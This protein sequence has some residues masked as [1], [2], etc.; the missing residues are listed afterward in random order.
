MS[1][2]RG[3]VFADNFSAFIDQCVIKFYGRY[4]SV[5][6]LTFGT[7]R[8]QAAHYSEPAKPV[9]SKGGIRNPRNYSVHSVSFLK[10]RICY[11]F[12][13]CILPPAFCLFAPNKPGGGL[14]KAPGYVTRCMILA[15]G[16]SAFNPN[17][18]IARVCAVVRCERE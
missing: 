10:T 4:K 17:A 8:H 1:F 11:S 12:P 18:H 16:P 5:P 13:S 9:L 2:S 6:R 14:G 3:R 7:S 15:P